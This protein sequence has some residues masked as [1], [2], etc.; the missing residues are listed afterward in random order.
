MARIYTDKN[1]WVSVEKTLRKFYQ[2]PLKKV[3][4]KLLRQFTPHNRHVS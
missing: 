4:Q 3:Y 1:P 2:K